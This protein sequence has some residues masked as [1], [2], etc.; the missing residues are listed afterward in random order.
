MEP[1]RAALVTWLILT[2]VVL[3]PVL[4]VLS[5]YALSL[6]MAVILSA[7][8]ASAYR[9]LRGKKIAPWAASAIVTVGLLVGV[10]GPLAW[11][12][13]TAVQE[14]IA[15]VSRETADGSLGIERLS[16]WL[17]NLPVLHRFIDDPVMLRNQIDSALLTLSRAAGN[18]ALQAVSQVPALVGQGAMCVI[19]VFFLL[20][21]GPRFYDWITG[22]LP[23]PPAIRDT[24]A[25]SFRGAASAVVLAS[26]AAAATQ[27]TILVT[28]YL[29][30]G[31]PGP[32]LAGFAAFILSWIPMVGVV[33]VWAFGT[34]WLFATGHPISAVI[35]LALGLLAST[36]DNVVRPWVLGGREAMH[37]LVSL[38]AILGGLA[39]FGLVG[40][41]LGPVIVAVAVAVVQT[42]PAVALYCG[43][44]IAETGLVPDLPPDVPQ[45]PERA[46]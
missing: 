24:L 17:V 3:L 41:F 34:I 46:H 32:F 45:D 36:S 22:K 13:A 10:L 23:L 31:I 1:R 28:G 7:L 26:M 11:F 5:N 33:P 6:A 40:V 30:L 42:W 21:D 44:P 12:V 16:T 9:A 18:V 4:W 29:L 15:L 20:V 38:I 2:T 43:V 27:A 25:D 14:T 8:C 19:A 39:A 37:P 35:M